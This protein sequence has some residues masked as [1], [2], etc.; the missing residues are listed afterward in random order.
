M[1]LQLKLCEWLVHNGW[2]QNKYHYFIGIIFQI[3]KKKKRKK[4]KEKANGVTV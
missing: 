2:D 4:I 1:W 3:Y